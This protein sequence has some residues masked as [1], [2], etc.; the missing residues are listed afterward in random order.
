MLETLLISNTI[1]GKDDQA[2]IFSFTD[3]NRIL[4]RMFYCYNSV[5]TINIQIG[6]ENYV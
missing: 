3:S 6:L 1:E 4:V 2:E 5:F